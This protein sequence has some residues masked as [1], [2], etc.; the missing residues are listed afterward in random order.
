MLYP[1]AQPQGKSSGSGT[2]AKPKPKPIPALPAVIYTSFGI[3]EAEKLQERIKKAEEYRERVRAAARNSDKPK[4][5][6]RTKQDAAA[7]KRRPS[8]P[9]VIYTAF[10]R[11]EADELRERIEKVKDRGKPSPSDLPQDIGQDEQLDAQSLPDLQSFYAEPDWPASRPLTEGQK[12]HVDHLLSIEDDT[13]ARSMLIGIRR[14]GMPSPKYL[15]DYLARFAEWGW[16]EI[17]DERTLELLDTIRQSNWDAWLERADSAPVE[18]AAQDLANDMIESVQVIDAA[19]GQVLLSRVGVL[20]AGGGQSVG[21]QAEEVQT[22]QGRELIFV[23]NH[24]NGAAASDADLRT[25]FLAGA[26]LLLVVTPR[27]YEYAYIRGENGMALVREGDASYEVS[28]ATAE[29]YVELTG[30]S[31]RQAMADRLNPPEFLMLQ[32]EDEPTLEIEVSGPLN[33]YGQETRV[34]GED[35]QSL[36]VYDFSEAPERFKILG[37]SRLNH[38][39]VLIDMYGEARFWID[40]DQTDVLNISE[41]D[42]ARVPTVD[43]RGQALNTE[44]IREPFENL[45]RRTV[46]FLPISQQEITGILQFGIK[47]E[48]NYPAMFDNRHPGLDFFAPAGTEVISL[49]PGEVTGVFIPDGAE[50]EYERVYG[51]GVKSHVAHGEPGGKVFD[52]RNPSVDTRKHLA[53]NWII[54]RSNRAYV[55][56]RSGNAYIL[57]GHLDP[58]SIQVGTHVI[59]GQIIGTVGVDE[60][61]GNDHLHL[62]V[63]TH[64]LY[65]VNLDETGEYE[66][67]SKDKPGAF[68]NPL[69]LFTEEL[70]DVLEDLFDEE[71]RFGKM[72]PFEKQMQGWAG[73]R[74]YY[75]SPDFRITSIWTDVTPVR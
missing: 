36:W 51:A 19:T 41:I 71:D 25:A 54:E 47:D 42:L 55:I 57:Y 30:R 59:A 22:F 24:P 50:T 52:P 75:R 60:I 31:W 27:G 66:H 70:E 68:I 72:E 15:N 46:D 9:A 29:E 38:S 63:R 49:T 3:Q 33:I 39:V 1:D 23:H 21:L 67:Y 74:P 26:E 16:D 6:K 35:K 73:G 5:Q 20:G 28:P 18:N 32:D 37:K 17:S 69:W 45:V 34:R 56:V 2:S 10:D 58:N 8:I 48:D 61:P 4:N 65:P 43:Q 12:Y 14:D 64:G 62:E 13:L 44:E 40:L 11:D 7:Q 53:D